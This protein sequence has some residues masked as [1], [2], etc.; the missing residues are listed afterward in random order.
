M[1][2]E[3]PSATT[4][5]MVSR[6]FSSLAWGRAGFFATPA[7][8]LLLMP[9]VRAVSSGGRASALP[10]EETARTRGINKSSFAGVAKKPA[11]PHASDENIRETIVVVVADGHSH[12]I[13]LDVQSCA[14]RHVRKG[15]IAVV[16]VEPQRG[17]LALVSGPVHAVHQQNILPAIAVVIEERAACAQR[18][19]EQFAAISAAVVPELDPR[20]VGNIGQT[21][22]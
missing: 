21:E 18:L 22:S 8:E 9:R 14:S 20:R 12:S 15:A 16:P 2:W 10:P 4:T 6:I 1:E 5:T 3:W 17:S 19:R 13:H 7:K 11:L